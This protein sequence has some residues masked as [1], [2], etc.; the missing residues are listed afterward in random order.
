MRTTFAVLA[1]LFAGVVLGAT[2]AHE[3]HAQ[4]KPPV[5]VVTEIAVR[6]IPG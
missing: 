6:N 3:L 4:N 1:A 2:A 5:Y